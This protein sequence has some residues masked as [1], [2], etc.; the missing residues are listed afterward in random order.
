MPPPRAPEAE[1][2]GQGNEGAQKFQ[3]EQRAEDDGLG[4]VRDGR[5]PG[6][7]G[8]PRADGEA[9]Q[10]LP[11]AADAA[12]KPQRRVVVAVVGSAAEEG[13]EEECR[14]STHY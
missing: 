8:E 6:A 4:L 13:E 7:V 9:G 2:Q 3:A 11:G 5:V 1:S 14:V 12:S 10:R